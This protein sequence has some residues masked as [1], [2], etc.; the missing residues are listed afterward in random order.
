VGVTERAC[1]SALLVAATLRRNGWKGTPRPCRRPGCAVARAIRPQRAFLPG[2][3]CRKRAMKILVRILVTAVALAVAAWVVPGI[4]TEQWA[5]HGTSAVSNDAS[6]A[7]TLIIVAVIFGLINAI[8]KPIIKAVGCAFYILTL[9]LIAIV[10]NGA[11]LYLTSY[12]AYDKLHQ[13]FHVTSFLAAVEG[14]LIVG[15]VTWVA[16]LILR[17]EE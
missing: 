15:I 6:I 2:A 7:K 13:P 3:S 1:E 8:I 4:H 16:H 10:V 17:D 9:G 11:L 5:L 14:A 12:I